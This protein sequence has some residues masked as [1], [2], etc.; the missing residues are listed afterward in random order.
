MIFITFKI[1][2]LGAV[3][4][5]LTAIVTFLMWLFYSSSIFL[6]GAKLVR[7]LGEAGSQRGQ[8]TG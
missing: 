3:Y 1:A 6:I 7:N 2:R 5:P 4:G 8:S